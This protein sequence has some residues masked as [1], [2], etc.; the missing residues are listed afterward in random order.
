MNEREN[1]H[2]SL[3][4][5]EVQLLLAKKRT[6]LAAV[7]GSG[8]SVCGNS[9]ASVRGNWVPRRGENQMGPV[10]RRKNRLS[11]VPFCRGRCYRKLLF[12]DYF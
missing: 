12:F 7:P 6:S 4:I 5:N 11:A 9:G 2:E 3:I 1:D 8:W 10:H